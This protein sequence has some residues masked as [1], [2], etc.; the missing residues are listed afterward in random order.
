MNT[1]LYQK[2]FTV[3]GIEARTNNAAEMSSHGIISKQ[4]DKFS[5]EN[6]LA[7]IPNK[8]DH[9]IIAGY[10]GY[11]SDKNGDYTFFLGARVISFD[12]VPQGMVIKQVP[13]GNFKIFTSEKGPIWEVVLKVWNKIWNLPTSEIGSDSN[14][15]YQFDYEIYDQRAQDPKA[16]I[17]DVYLGVK[18]L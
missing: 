15:S 13:A 6:I 3:V 4:W 16:S 10:T 5:K 7:M 14:R 1:S 12:Q 8:S 17:V 2:A 9:S 18:Q 11:E